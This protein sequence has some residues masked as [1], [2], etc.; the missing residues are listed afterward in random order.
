MQTRVMHLSHQLYLK[1]VNYQTVNFK[2][3]EI[4]LIRSQMRGLPNNTRQYQIGWSQY[5]SPY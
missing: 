2:V 3:K 5:T 4:L 1:T